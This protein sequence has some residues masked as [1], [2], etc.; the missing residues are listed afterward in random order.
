MREFADLL[1]DLPWSMK[2]GWAL[3]VSAGL[4]LAAWYRFQQMHPVPVP[5]QAP[6]APVVEPTVVSR[7]P[8]APATLSTTPQTSQDEDRSPKKS[9]RRR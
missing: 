3:W 5:V 7:P 6:V 9:R 8:V 4:T 1:V 2:I